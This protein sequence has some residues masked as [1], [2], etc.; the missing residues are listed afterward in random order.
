MFVGRENELAVLDRLYKSNAFQM[1][2]LYGRRRVGKTALLEEFTKGKRALFFTAQAQGER[3]NLRD[4]SKTAYAFFDFPRS[5][6]PFENWIDALRF[7]SDMATE[8]PFIFVF[9]EFPYAAKASPSLPSAMQIAIDQGFKKTSALIALCGSNQGFMEDEVLGEKSPLYGRRTAQLKMRPFDFFDA[10]KMFPHA[11]PIEKIMYY[12]SLGGTPYYLAAIDASASYLDNMASLFFDRTGLM[13][14]EPNMLMRQELRETSIYSSV[15]R[16]IACGST[17]SN[18]IADRAG[19]STTSVTMYLK[20]LANL[21]LIERRVPFGEPTK[22]KRSLYRIDDFAFSF[23]YRFVS[24]YVGS[25]ERGLGR[26]LAPRLLEGDR[27]NEYLGHAFEQVCREWVVRQAAKGSLPIQVTS[28]GSWWGTD[29]TRHEQTDIDLVAAD[30]LDRNI[31]LGECKWRGVFDETEVLNA[32]KERQGLIPGFRDHWFYVFSK[33]RVSSGSL[34]KA[35]R[36][37]NARFISAD[38]LYES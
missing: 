22:T 11:T 25:I 34:E 4:F 24:P 23:W 15:L 36:S 10:A 12:A 18:E 28:V 13:F 37:G 38:E 14:D 2:V 8:S 29:P 6:S 9:D 26:Q 3:D 35:A 21:G 31:I 7:V 32:L 1:L 20:T 27:I 5:T 17:K 30:E 16:A 33:H 19:I